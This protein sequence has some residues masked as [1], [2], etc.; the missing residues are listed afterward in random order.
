MGQLVIPFKQSS[1]SVQTWGNGPQLVLC[2]HGYGESAAH[3]AFLQQLG[4]SYTVA[5]I[6]LPYHGNTIW[7]ESGKLQP[8]E[9][10]TI[11]KSLLQQLQQGNTTLQDKI[12]LLGYS[13][14]G[15]IALSL[16]EEY[17]ESFKKLVLLAPDGLKLNR[18]YW[19][20]TQ[21]WLGNRLFRFTMK[22][23][24]WFFT[25]LKLLNRVG[26]VNTS[27]FKF[28]NFYIGDTTIR[29]LLYRRWTALAA[30]RPRLEKV[31]R[32]V[33]ENNTQVR[34]VYGQYDKIIVPVV[35]ERFIKTI[36]AQGRMRVIPS[37]HR[38]LEEKWLTDFK[39]VIG[40]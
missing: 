24:G 2:L 38:L 12:I 7:Q 21:T 40:E 26:M 18:W 14:G 19:L 20:A 22:H 29:E 28:V 10:L 6:D 32:L 39:Q 34:L 35:G 5:A 3:F 30:F 23:P 13:L 15:R 11:I 25:M 37:G 17:P 16:Y 31:H 1:F 4:P 33:K 36:P 8:R 27:I 9:L